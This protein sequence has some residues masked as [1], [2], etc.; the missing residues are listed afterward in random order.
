MEGGIA[1]EFANGYEEQGVAGKGGVDHVG[2]G[3][4][5]HSGEDDESEPVTPQQRTRLSF[6]VEQ[7]DG[8]RVE[9]EICCRFAWQRVSN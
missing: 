2:H 3:Q 4:C 9:V 1:H 5:D 6:V 8:V 7:G